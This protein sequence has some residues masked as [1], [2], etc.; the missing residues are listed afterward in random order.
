LKEKAFQISNEAGV[1]NGVFNVIP[2]DR[3]QTA[4]I[5]K[6]I[7]D[8]HDVDCIS[9]TGS[10]IIGK[11]NFLKKNIETLNNEIDFIP[12]DSVES[13]GFHRQKGAA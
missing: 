4:D 3:E 13:I 9:F 5:S 8:S 11:V 6:F 1:P 10:S 12:S 2:A 7:C